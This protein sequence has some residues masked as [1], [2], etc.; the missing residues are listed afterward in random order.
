MLSVTSNH[1]RYKLPVWEMV[2]ASR[3]SAD[4]VVDVIDTAHGLPGRPCSL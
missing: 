1:A 2:V 3:I 4:V